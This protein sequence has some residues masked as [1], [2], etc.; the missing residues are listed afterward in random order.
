MA[1]RISV[2]ANG[3]TYA[4]EDRTPLTAFLESRGQA[5]ERVVVERN[6]EALAP[7]EARSVRL[8]DG[9]RLEVVQIVAGG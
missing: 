5:I 7:S 2:V 4:I 6:G 9:D 1:D 3:R 8:S